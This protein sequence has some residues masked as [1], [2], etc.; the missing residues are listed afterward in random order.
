MG[1][2]PVGVSEFFLGFIWNCLSYFIYTARITFTSIVSSSSAKN[3]R[4]VCN[5]QRRTKKPA[6]C[7]VCVTGIAS[8]H[9]RKKNFRRQ[10]MWMIILYSK[11]QVK[12]TSCESETYHFDRFLWSTN[13]STS[14]RF[15]T[16]SL[17]L[18]KRTHL[19][20]KYNPGHARPEESIRRLSEKK[21][22]HHVQSVMYQFTQFDQCWAKDSHSSPKAKE[23]TTV[24]KS[25]K[26]I[27]PAIPEC[28]LISLLETF[29]T[30]TILFPALSYSNT[31]EI[32]KRH[33]CPV[34]SWV[35]HIS[36][37]HFRS[38]GCS[39]N[40]PRVYPSS[41]PGFKTQDNETRSSAVDGQTILVHR[42]DPSSDTT[43]TS[44]QVILPLI[45]HQ[46]W[47]ATKLRAFR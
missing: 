29:Y 37:N 19:P 46:T 35:K 17:E 43:Q 41:F 20:V 45:S 5:W 16:F 14:C 47:P 8:K 28:S 12:S 25:E 7:S 42:H 24:Q 1:S 2:N 10:A 15:V 9:F 3:N 6:C 33:N 36:I 30:R 26:G 21:P 34:S 44:I 23:T 4:N 39:Y 32:R 11:I 38:I 13:D 40:M 22:T 31:K 27:S 18:I